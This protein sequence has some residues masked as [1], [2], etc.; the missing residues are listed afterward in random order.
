MMCSPALSVTF[1][2]TSMS[3]VCEVY[4]SNT[5]NASDTDRQQK[6]PDPVTEIV[7]NPVTN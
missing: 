4:F 2:Y 3:T 5:D 1:Q 6:Q 7:R